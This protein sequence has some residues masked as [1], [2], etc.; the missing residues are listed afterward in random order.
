MRATVSLP[1]W[2]PAMRATFLAVLTNFPPVPNPAIPRKYPCAHHVNSQTRL[3]GTSQGPPLR[4]KSH[5]PCDDANKRK[6]A[7]V[8]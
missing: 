5:R 3:Q 6:S 2:E 4:A 7:G 8:C 1:L